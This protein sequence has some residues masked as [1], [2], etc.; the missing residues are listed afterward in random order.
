M[1]RPE[2][3][4]EVK[5]K[6]DSLGI[7]LKVQPRLGLLNR[8]EKEEMKRSRFP[9]ERRRYPRFALPLALAYMCGATKD[10]LRT[11]DVSL[12]GTRI[13]PDRPIVVDERLNL[14]ILFENEAIKPVG[15]VVRSGQWPNRK[16][17][18]GISFEA[19]SRQCVKRL[20]RFLD[21]MAGKRASADW[22]KDLD[23][24]RL[25]RLQPESFES[26]RLR[27][28]FLTWVHKSYPWDYERYAVRPEIGTNDVRDF[29]RNKGIDQVN[30]HYLLKSLGA[31]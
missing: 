2:A 1:L 7:S 13:Q 3:E 26:D 29:L 31:K 9:T 24:S 17:D 20:A 15:K 12:G 30:I 19:M 6:P 25:R 8:Y 21:G 16:Y 11:I 18:V 27:R 4:L 10:T 28:N 14:I 5:R 23:Q 22:G